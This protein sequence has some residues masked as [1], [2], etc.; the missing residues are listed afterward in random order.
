MGTDVVTVPLRRLDWILLGSVLALVA[1]SALLVWS[2]TSHR[3]DLTDG[4]STAY[5][6]KQL[7]NVVIGLV[8]LLGVTVA[9]HRWVRIVAPFVY[10]LSVSG[11]VLVLTMG[12]TING[13]RSWVRVLGLSIQPS[14]F[15]KLA[16]V[17]GMALV[18]AERSSARWQRRVGTLDVLLMLVIAGVPALLILLQPD[19][20]TMLVLSAT[21]FGVLAV[22]GA[23]RRWLVVVLASAGGVAAAALAGGVLKTYQVDRFLAFVNPDLDPRGAGYNVE[24]ARIAI[25]NGGLFGQGLFHGS[26]TRSG[27]V[28]E[29]Q[30]DFVFTVAG[31]ELGLL[32]AGL[33][34][35]AA[36]P[37]H[38]ARPGHRPPRRGR[39]RPG[40]RRRHRLLVRLPGLPEHRHV[41]R[42]HAGDRRTPAVRVVRRVVTLRGDA[43]GR[44]AAEHPCALARRGRTS[45]RTRSVGCSSGGSVRQMSSTQFTVHT[46]LSPSDVMELFT[47]F[48]ADRADRW[49]NLDEAHF[50]VHDLGPDWAEV[51]EGNAMG[52]ERE[53][54]SWDTAAGTVVIDTLDSNLWALGSGWRYELSPASDG[55]DVHVTLT[56]VPKSLKGRIVGA[57]IPVVG[58]RVLGK[59]FRSLLAKAEE[60]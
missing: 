8:L 50:K 49:P 55:T 42:H 46:S 31:E 9:D 32:G 18:L 44:V 11:L 45:R 14:E 12:S 13:S 27:F 21:V 40:R 19:L 48:G 4:D 37:R 10:L 36:V 39:L 54:Y 2:A 23:R 33:L 22:S 52:W 57:L 7:V 35:A 26:Q 53:R 47:D 5:L 60:R 34:I 16:V 38:L 43:R 29:Q 1:L 58:A 20:G 51:T 17:I 59:Q 15:A 25:G 30:T 3:V 41:P 6:R 24:Q 28:P 56:R